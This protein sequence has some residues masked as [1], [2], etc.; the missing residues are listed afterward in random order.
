MT[1]LSYLDAELLMVTQL[2]NVVDKAPK[3]D[4]HGR[5]EQL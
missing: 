3:G 4:G 2:S 1:P 5:D